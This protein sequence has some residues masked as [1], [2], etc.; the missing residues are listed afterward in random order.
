MSA[1]DRQ[2][3]GPLSVSIDDIKLAG[4]SCKLCHR[5][6]KVVRHGTPELASRAC[7]FACDCEIGVVTWEHELAPNRK[8]WARLMKQ[9]RKGDVALVIFNENKLL[10]PGFAGLN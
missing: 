10:P 8:S 4:F 1:N 2:M 3:M 9:A 6:V 7:L 5:P